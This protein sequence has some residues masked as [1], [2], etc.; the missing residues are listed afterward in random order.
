MPK[1]SPTSALK[2]G[3]SVLTMFCS[4]FSV[5]TL[6]VVVS[7][8]CFEAIFAQG[9]AKIDPSP[10]LHGQAITIS[11]MTCAPNAGAVAVIGQSELPLTAG[12][13]LNTF[14][15]DTK[16]LQPGTYRV[17]LRCGTANVAQVALRILSREAPPS[18]N[19][20]CVQN[21][22]PRDGWFDIKDR[23]SPKLQADLEIRPEPPCS[24]DVRWIV[25]ME[26][27]L[28]FHVQGFTEWRDFADNARV[29]LHVFING[30]EVANLTPRLQGR[31]NPDSGPDVLWT[32]LKFE[33]NK[34]ATDSRDVWAQI[35]R[36]LR[37]SEHADISIGPAGGPYWRT[38]ATIAVNSYPTG[39]FRFA[40]GVIVAMVV[41]LFI[42][43]WQS[44][45][46]RDSNGAATPPFSLAKH[47]M[48]V[49]FVVVVGAYLFV[50]MTTGA[51]AATSA[52]ALI[53]IGISGAT[54]LTAIAMDASKRE[55]AAEKKPLLLEEKAGLERELNTPITGLVAQ[56]NAAAGTPQAVPLKADVDAK[57]RRLGGV[58][59]ELL[60]LQPA[61]SRGW[62]KDLLS[63]ENG[64]SFHRLQ[65]AVWTIVLVGTFVVAVWRAFAM[66]DFDA[67]TLGLMGISSG[68]YLGFKFPEKP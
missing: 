4:S 14:Q 27:N 12:K 39:L 1:N 63:D 65:I 26:S 2:L 53:L 50:M 10:V 11:G 28:A 25:R 61:S 49:W 6:S 31:P 37:A 19:V 48:A 3:P 59:D 55:A 41:G 24:S 54:G 46:L 17:T 58:N 7:L 35:V 20:T 51:A 29:P 16:G 9:M 44:S 21:L 5:T 57:S 43:G 15:S 8:L 22:N 47:Q 13:E 23:N 66:P 68:M 45:M 38:E 56:L 30:I 52:T 62:L 42:F 33:S 18:P 32:P 67:T 34:D 36:I 60:A 40:I 64:V